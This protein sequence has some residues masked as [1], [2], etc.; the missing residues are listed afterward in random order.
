MSKFVS[1]PHKLIFT[2]L[3]NHSCGNFKYLMDKLL[4]FIKRTLKKP[5]NL[6]LDSKK[7]IKYHG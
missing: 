5:I 4:Q 7:R 3:A 2:P 1:V 6:E